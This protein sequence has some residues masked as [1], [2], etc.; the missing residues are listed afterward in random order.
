MRR[1]IEKVQHRTEAAP[2]TG[3]APYLQEE[4]RAV[5]VH[6]AELVLGEGVFCQAP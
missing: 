4:T 5:S 2:A 1:M 3:F 6:G